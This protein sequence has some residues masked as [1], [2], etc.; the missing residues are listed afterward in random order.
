MKTLSIT[1]IVFFITLSHF[2]SFANDRY[3]YPDEVRARKAYKAETTTGI[4]EVI[5]GKAFLEYDRFRVALQAGDKIHR[6]DTIVTVAGSL[7]TIRMPD[8]SQLKLIPRT[9]VFFNKIAIFT[10]GQ[11]LDQTSL[12]MTSGG[13]YYKSQPNSPEPTL[14]IRT[15]LATI[16]SRGASFFTG[17]DIKDKQTWVSVNKGTVEVYNP[18]NTKN[19]DSIESGFAMILRNS[20][21]SQQKMYNWQ[22]SLNFVFRDLSQ[23]ESSFATLLATH[24]EEALKKII[25][26]QKDTEHW[27]KIS[28]IW[29]KAQT[30][31]ENRYSQN[32]VKIETLLEHHQ[33][34]RIEKLNQFSFQKRLSYQRALASERS[35][36]SK[37]SP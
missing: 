28:K 13:I 22:D 19:I 10:D 5:S 1:A 20:E 30:E 25:P 37:N 33:G 3:R 12:T 24:K 18:F 15:K 8:Q 4:V 17:T 29:S 6:G 2:L 7:V 27:T 21:F 23:T 31:W 14:V 9:S 32:L 34:D 16:T 11:L 35:H 36:I 26:W